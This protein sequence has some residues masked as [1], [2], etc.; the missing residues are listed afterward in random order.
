MTVIVTGNS[1]NYNSPVLGVPLAF[2]FPLYTDADMDVFY[3]DSLMAV[4]N[5]DY[6]VQL[7]PLSLPTAYANATVTPLAGLITK[8]AA[9]VAA[10]GTDRITLLR[11]IDVTQD[12][13]IPVSPKLDEKG[14]Q[15]ALDRLALIIQQIANSAFRALRLRDNDIDGAGKFDARGN[16]VI[17]AATG[18][19]TAGSLVTL[20]QFQAAQIAAGAVP[21]PSGADVN[22]VLIVT[23]PGV[24]GWG[25]AKSLS[26]EVGAPVWDLTGNFSYSYTGGGPV[27]FTLNFGAGVTARGTVS[28]VSNRANEQVDISLKDN[29][30]APFF[31][32]T[33][34]SAVL[35]YRMDFAAYDWRSQAGVQWMTL[36][37]TALTVL[38]KKAM[39]AANQLSSRNKIINGSMEVAQ[40]GTSFATPA[41]NTY[42]LDRW[43]VNYDGTIGAFTLSQGVFAVA[44][45]AGRERKNF[46]R[47][48][49]TGA[50]S[51]QT[52]KHV[53]QRVAGVKTFAGQVY[54][55]SFYASAD[56]A[57]S[58]DLTVNQ[59]FGT[60]GAPSADVVNALATANLTTVPT[61]FEFSGTLADLTGKTIGTNGDDS[62]KIQFN[63]PLNVTFTIDIWDVQFEEGNVATAYEQKAF[64]RELQDCLAFYRKSFPYAVAPA[65]NTGGIGAKMCAQGVAA[66][67]IQ[68]LLGHVDFNPPMRAGS[69]PTITYFNPSA[70][71]AQARNQQTGTDCTTTGAAG[72]VS[73]KG[74]GTGATMVAGSV[75]GQRIEFHWTAEAE[76]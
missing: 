9:V 43:R 60:G 38:G 35:S 3:G 37:S 41:I 48:N 34:G 67:A 56:A 19:S 7:N 75:V 8:V 74:F 66:S 65:Q 23:A 70:A 53:S 10:G 11:T 73:E 47:W 16:E 28:L 61:R 68:Q 54:T 26:M 62:I 45:P 27:T 31:H 57:R 4:L 64:E 25:L 13:D 29:N 72:S 69:T 24:H 22:K 1:V 17:N 21:T 50:G 49:Q 5:V 39:T 55:L 42:T 18:I 6:T 20:A 2:G 40:R 33:S 63:L 30:N 58:V 76:L 71:N 46:L 44:T 14:L 59:F 32:M 51:A 52:L 36:S 12:Y 15:R